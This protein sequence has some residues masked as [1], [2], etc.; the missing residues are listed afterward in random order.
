MTPF[1]ASLGCQADDGVDLVEPVGDF[2]AFAEGVAQTFERLAAA[3]QFDAVGIAVGLGRAVFEV[4]GGLH[5][6]YRSG[7]RNRQEQE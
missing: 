2:P 6:R 3:G 1:G 7:R 5:Q 4:D